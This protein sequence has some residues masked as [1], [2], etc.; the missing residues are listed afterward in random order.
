[1]SNESLKAKLAAYNDTYAKQC[2]KH[3][4]RVGLKHKNLYTPLVSKVSTM[5]ET[6]DSRAN[7]HTP[8]AYSRPCTV[9]NSGPCVCMLV[10]P[11]LKNPT[12]VTNT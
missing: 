6:S 5:K 7:I 1:M 3:P 9:A 2:A 8:V 10:S 12:N 4:E 11:P